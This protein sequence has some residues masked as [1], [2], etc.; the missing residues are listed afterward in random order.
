MHRPL[1]YCAHPGCSVLVIRGRCTPHTV[2]VNADV[3]RWYCTKPWAR[4]RRQVLGAQAYTC[5]Q[6]GQVSR[7]LDVDHIT[8]HQ[9]SRRLFWDRANLQALCK[10]CHTRKTRQ[11][12][13]AQFPH[14]PARGGG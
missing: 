12:E 9:G 4:L 8:P 13:S 2:R 5:A 1:R 3:R 7:D 10:P 14:L 11:E 6:C